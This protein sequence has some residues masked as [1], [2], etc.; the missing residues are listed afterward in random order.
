MK[1]NQ[2]TFLQSIRKQNLLITES[3]LLIAVSGGA[4]S[5]ALL[6]LLVQLRERFKLTLHAVTLDHSLRPDSAND[7]AFVQSMAQKWE[8]SFISKRVD[9]QAL[10]ESQKIGIEAAGRQARYNFF[11]DVARKMG[12]DMILTAHH[13]DDQTET[14]FMHILRGSG[15]QG[16]LGMQIKAPLPE[17][18]DL[19]LIRPLLSFRRHQIENYCTQYKLEPRLD[20]SN[21]NTDFLRNNVRHNILPRLRENN[22]QF[23]KALNQLAD[24]VSIE[25]DYMQQQFD[26]HIKPHIQFGN[27]VLI[28][29]HIFQTWHSAMQSR[30]ILTA[31]NFLHGEA[32]YQHIQHA[33]YIAKNGKQGAIAQFTDNLQL[34]VDYD[35]LK[36]ENI[37]LPLPIGKYLQIEGE[38]RVNIPGETK[39]ENWKLMASNETL[40]NFDAQLHIP[41]GVIVSLRTRQAGDRFRPLGMKGHSQKLKKWLI[42]H[43]I[44]QNIR[45]G[46]PILT[47]DGKIAALLLHDSWLIAEEFIIKSNSQYN[48]YFKIAK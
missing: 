44:P 19:L 15:M 23:D 38:H 22:L 34:R 30:S 33:Q 18:Q 31:L 48:I 14:I 21:L 45:D 9:V 20:P 24:I 6:H 1:L 29:R 42:N 39:L 2:D 46:L 43:K 32:N 26:A 10:A 47:V 7:T 27:R 25:Q 11:A 28:D 13:A 41:D 5:L 40:L 12:T 3:T 4:D 8:V 37:D 17:H 16:L 36:I 35:L